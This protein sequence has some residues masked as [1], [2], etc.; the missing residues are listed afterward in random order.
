MGGSDL[1]TV[2]AAAVL[3][4]IP[5]ILVARDMDRI[6]G[7]PRFFFW[8]P[9]PLVGLPIV[10]PLVY[11]FLVRERLIALGAEA[12]RKREALNR[13]R[14]ERGAGTDDD[15]RRPRPSG[16]RRRGRGRP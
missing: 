7:L 11:W 13:A 15:A 8:T 5:T 4:W 14:R 12:A 10:G 9:L 2:V 1:L 16:G 6:P 3:W